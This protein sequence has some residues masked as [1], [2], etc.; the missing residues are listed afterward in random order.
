MHFILAAARATEGGAAAADATMVRRVADVLVE[1]TVPDTE[2]V[3]KVFGER[4]MLL[5]AVLGVCLTVNDDKAVALFLC[6][7]D[8]GAKAVTLLAGADSSSS[9]AM[10]GRRKMDL[11]RDFDVMVKLLLV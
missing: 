2:D 9:A 5:M 1:E 3:G 11:Y 10:D 8:K 7:V 6:V 4:I